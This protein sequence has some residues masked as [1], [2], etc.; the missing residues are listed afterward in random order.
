MIRSSK[1]LQW[2]IPI[3][4]CFCLFFSSAALALVQPGQPVP[5]A[6][7]VPGKLTVQ[8][9]DNVATGKFQRGFGS[10]STGLSSVDQL[11]AG[12]G[13]T[14]LHAIFTNAKRPAVNS[15]MSDLTRYYEI[16]FPDSLPLD[17]VIK[18]L[19]QNPNIRM[20]EPVWQYYIDAT[21]NDPL[22]MNQ[23]NMAPPG[24]DPQMYNA[25][26]LSTGSDSIKIAIVDTGVL[27]KHPDLMGNIWVNPGEDINHNGVVWDVDDLNGI[28]DDA[29]GF[30]D[31]LIGYD[32][33]TAISNPAP[34]EDCCTRDNDPSDFN[35]HGT[36]VSGIVAAM[37]NNNLSV[38]GVAG[39]WY[40][41]SR[42]FGGCRIM[43][44]RAGGSNNAGQGT[45]NSNDLADAINY[46]IMMHANAINASWGGGGYSAPLE[47]AIFN[48]VNSGITFAHAAGND[49]IDNQGAEDQVPGVLSVAA[50]T[51][52]DT[53]ASY[54]NYGTWITVSAPGDQILS[55]V[56]N[57]Y[58][59]G[60]AIFSG[61]SMAAPHV[62]ALSGLIRSMMPSLTRKQVDSILVNTA[63]NIDAQNPSY[64][65]QLGTGRINAFRALSALANAKFTTDVD[66][67][68]VP[69]TVNFTDQSPNSPTTWAWD[70]GDGNTSTA[71][72]PA[73]QYTTP[74][75]YT[76]S[77]KITEPR[78]L[79]EEHLKNYMWVRAD[80]LKI[81]SVVVDP[82]SIAVVNVR[83]TNTS[84]I[85]Y[86][87]LPIY[88]SSDQGDTLAS[89]SGIG[90][91]SVVGTRAASFSQVNFDNAVSSFNLYSIGMTASPIGHYQFLTPGSG[92]ILKLYIS[93]PPT[94]TRGSVIT[95]DTLSQGPGNK[96]YPKLTS[97]WGDYWPVFKAGKVVVRACR[98]GKVLC[99]SGVI[100][101]SDLSALVSYLTTGLPVLD[102][103]GGNV[104]GVGTIDLGDLSFLVAY[105][106]GIGGPPPSN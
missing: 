36:H 67:G 14:D 102:P 43:C 41:G 98:R 72:N 47:N 33:V 53:K 28:D 106:T 27:Y 105:L 22:Y 61:T 21:P 90:G 60:T 96:F 12:F 69:L 17:V 39:G 34:G 49:G 63:D 85:E 58:T 1:T 6:T 97:L 56:S 18:G 76:V 51:S 31:D 29:N 88:F 24:P 91:I 7:K 73:H 9:E 35:G 54:S 83:L 77:L 20:A 8:F 70:F 65:G 23:W 99:G 15:G 57:A 68:N 89:D 40:G 10:V 82:G 95:I 93:V 46:A 5:K 87:E 2:A 13:V 81:D 26:D 25:W 75:M 45:L 4:A 84:Q 100:D 59:P 66:R 80:T 48:A 32:F 37:N 16:T 86:L 19:T 52:T 74:G 38:T 44:L 101:L 11:L 62:A 30:V 94:A 92:S 78:G 79:G 3:C 55:T 42:S 104:N 64:I 103:Y 71:Q 50:T